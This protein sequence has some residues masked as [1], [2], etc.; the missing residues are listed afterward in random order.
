MVKGEKLWKSQRGQ[1]LVELALTLPVIILVLFGILEFGRISYSYIVI[2]HAARE[3]ARAGAVGKTDAEIVATIRETAP[4][5][6]ADTNLHITKLEPSES[7]RTSGLPLTVEVAYDVE[8]V[9]PLFDKLLPNPFTLKSRVTM[10]I[11]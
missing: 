3:G 1:S 5:P 9:T 11:E 4:L 6:N 7:A 2:T 8:L 10:R